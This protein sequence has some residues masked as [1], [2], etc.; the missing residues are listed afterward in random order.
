MTTLTTQYGTFVTLARTLLNQSGVFV[1]YG[2]FDEEV[3][4]HEV[5][6]DNR[7]EQKLQVKVLLRAKFLRRQADGFVPSLESTALMANNG[8]DPKQGDYI[9]E[10]DGKRSPI[11]DITVIAP[12]GFPILYY[13]GFRDG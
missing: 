6:G 1:T 11:T 12:D 7:V 5:G 10:P 9:I 2:R 13:L 3:S 8:F 4:G